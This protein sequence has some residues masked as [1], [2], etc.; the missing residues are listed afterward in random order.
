[1]ASLEERVET[2]TTA[3]ERLTAVIEANG[4][5]GGAATTAAPAKAAAKADKPAAAA[6]KK[7]AAKAKFTADQ[8]KA[9]IVNVKDTVSEEAAREIIQEHAGEGKKLADLVTMPSVFEA[10]M[11]S[12]EAALAGGDEEEA[13]EGDDGL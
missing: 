8:V 3:V 10:V 9:A 6:P 1:M 11:A 2:L 7:A 4:V 5:G 13:E 12:C